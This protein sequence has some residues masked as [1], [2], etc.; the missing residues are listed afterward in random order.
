[1]HTLWLVSC[2][3]SSTI[4]MANEWPI[5]S[6]TGEQRPHRMTQRYF[7]DSGYPSL[8]CLILLLARELYLH[9][10]WWKREVKWKSVRKLYTSLY[11]NKKYYEA[12]RKW[13]KKNN[14]QTNIT[15]YQTWQVTC[16]PCHFCTFFLK[17]DYQTQRGVTRRNKSNR[18]ESNLKADPRNRIARDK[19]GAPRG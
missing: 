11:L 5:F 19:D 13:G 12:R 10:C 7:L 8:N 3:L 15:P 6:A 18:T 16:Q 1:M 4:I 14:E 2:R 9:T 17:K